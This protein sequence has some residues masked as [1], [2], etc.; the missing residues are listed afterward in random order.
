MELAA[1]E[2]IKEFT[3]INLNSLPIGAKLLVQCKKDWRT[4][5]VSAVFD[6]NIILQICSPS[7]RTY[8]KK[9]AVE[10]ILQFD[11]AFHFLGEGMWQETFV[12][13]DCRW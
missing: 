2:Q 9:C 5:V 8:R 11:G 7:G 4:A 10:T 13:Y 12:K 6:E 3:E 1:T